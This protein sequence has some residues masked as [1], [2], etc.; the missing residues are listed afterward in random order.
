MGV[1]YIRSGYD[2][3]LN[4]VVGGVRGGLRRAEVT[5]YIVRI[6]LQNYS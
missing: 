5:A 4:A 1:T 2:M 6:A 3:G